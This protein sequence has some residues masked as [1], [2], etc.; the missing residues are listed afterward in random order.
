MSM[1]P[2]DV[3]AEFLEK[4]PKN[5]QNDGDFHPMVKAI[6]KKTPQKKQIQVFVW[7][8]IPSETPNK[9]LLSRVVRLQNRVVG[10][11]NSHETR[12]LI[13]SSPW[14]NVEMSSHGRIATLLSSFHGKIKSNP[15]NSP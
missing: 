10:P 15:I 6:R 1:I 4:F 7:G 11:L 8:C 14:K 12:V 13:A 9:A 2:W 3:L 5:H